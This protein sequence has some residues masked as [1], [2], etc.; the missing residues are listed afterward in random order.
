[1]C[2]GH[3]F[4]LPK[5]YA[6]IKEYKTKNPLVSQEVFEGT[7]LM[8]LLVLSN[9]IKGYLATIILSVFLTDPEAMVVK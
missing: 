4:L 9:L 1:M 7:E 2:K 8:M 6:H 5:N 3:G